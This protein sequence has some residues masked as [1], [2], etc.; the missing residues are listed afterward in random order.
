M[1]ANNRVGFTL[2]E[3]MVAIAVIA[4]M[5]TIISPML[6]VRRPGQ[7]RKEFVGTLNALMRLASQQATVS[8]KIHRVLFSLKDNKMVKVTVQIKG[9]G[10][11]SKGDPIFATIKAPYL[12]SSIKW[13]SNL[14]VKQFF[15]EGIDEKAREGRVSTEFW[16]V[17]MPEGLAQD[18]IINAVDMHDGPRNKP[19]Q[20]GLVLNPFSVQFKMYDSFQK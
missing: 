9:E 11:D 7:E 18:I 16:F 17:I 6:R 5:A 19:Q 13:P 2:V 10:N 14:L 4:L 1:R 12:S 15:I 20:V 3:I 8:R